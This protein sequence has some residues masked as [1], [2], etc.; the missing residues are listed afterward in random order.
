MTDQNSRDRALA[1]FTDAAQAHAAALE[2]VQEAEGELR[3]AHAH[4]SLAGTDFNVLYRDVLGQSAV[5][6]RPTPASETPEVPERPKRTRRTKEQIAADKAAE[7]A[8]KA[9][10]EPTATAETQSEEAASAV[11]R[12]PDSY[13]PPAQPEPTWPTYPAGG[14]ATHLPPPMSPSPV[15]NDFNPFG[16]G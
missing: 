4:P 1:F 10:P 11:V 2:V 9:Q 3:W 16:Q 8:A 12:S 15:S 13:A 7:E 6:V 14:A 5:T